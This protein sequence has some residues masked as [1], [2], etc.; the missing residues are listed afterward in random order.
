MIL[1]PRLVFTVHSHQPGRLSTDFECQSTGNGIKWFG[2]ANASTYAI[3]LDRQ[4]ISAQPRKY[5]QVEGPSG[6]ACNESIPWD[7]MVLAEFYNLSTNVEHT[8]QLTTQFGRNVTGDQVNLL[9]VQTLYD[10]HFT[11]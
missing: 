5:P 8:V 2:A 11:R 4:V 3:Q 1:P 7:C 6:I 9:A 10:T